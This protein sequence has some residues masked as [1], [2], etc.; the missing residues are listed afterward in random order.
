MLIIW[1]AFLFIFFL[2][3]FKIYIW[4]FLLLLSSL[5]FKTFPVYLT[6]LLTA[7][8]F[9]FLHSDQ[10]LCVLQQPPVVPPVSSRRRWC[11]AAGRPVAFRRR[12]S[13]GKKKKKKKKERSKTSVPQHFQPSGKKKK[14]LCFVLDSCAEPVRVIYWALNALAPVSSRD[15]LG[16]VGRFRSDPRRGAAGGRPLSHSR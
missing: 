14:K 5:L 7:A 2:F 6:E 15:N 1:D 13:G 3:L 16:P 4:D 11:H 9:L 12:L 8:R 10:N